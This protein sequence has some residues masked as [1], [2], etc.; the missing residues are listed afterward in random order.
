MVKIVAILFN[1]IFL[2]FLIYS[3]TLSPS[4]KGREEWLIF[5]LVFGTP[6]IS[7]I[8]LLGDRIRKFKEQKRLVQIL[9]I[10]V[11]LGLILFG[12][13]IFKSAESSDYETGEPFS[14]NV[15]YFSDGELLFNG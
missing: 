11:I 13:F 9:I 7:L 1:L 4:I 8:A 10:V 6:V 2:G 3:F 5:I 12:Y 15:N 14:K